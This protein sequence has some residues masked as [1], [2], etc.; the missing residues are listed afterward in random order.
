MNK[1]QFIKKY[2]SLTANQKA[3]TAIAVNVKDENNNLFA[4]SYSWN[5]LYRE[6]IKNNETSRILLKAMRDG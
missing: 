3:R 6:I 1:R 4:T 2:R 5:D